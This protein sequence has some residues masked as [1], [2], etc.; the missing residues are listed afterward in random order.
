MELFHPPTYLGFSGFNPA[1]AKVW[2]GYFLHPITF[3]TYSSCV[4]VWYSSQEN[5]E[6]YGYDISLLDCRIQV[7]WRVWAFFSGNKLDSLPQQRQMISLFLHYWW[8]SA[9]HKAHKFTN[10]NFSCILSTLPKLPTALYIPNTLE[11][12]NLTVW[13]LLKDHVSCS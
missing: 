10:P 3:C 7:V 9:S 11:W 12:F 8:I 6:Q 13:E 4:H 1:L 2:I 5:M